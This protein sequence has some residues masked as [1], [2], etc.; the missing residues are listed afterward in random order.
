VLLQ[1]EF[2]SSNDDD[3]MEEVVPVRTASSLQQ[4]WSKS[5]L[6]ITTKL[7]S[8]TNWNPIRSGEGECLYVQPISLILYANA[9]FVFHFSF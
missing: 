3:S 9:N 4:K 6:P 8:I 1:G 7:I 5:V 2:L